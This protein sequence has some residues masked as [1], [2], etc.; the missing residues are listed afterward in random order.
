M[1][2]RAATE[3]AIPTNINVCFD[4]R[5]CDPPEAAAKGDG[6]R[7]PTTRNHPKIFKGE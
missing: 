6:N 3:T 2:R 4:P 7:A 1:K 5:W